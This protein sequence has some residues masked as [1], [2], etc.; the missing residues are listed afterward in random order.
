LA[1]GGMTVE[2]ML[3]RMDSREVAEWQAF[4]NLE[5][6]GAKRKDLRAAIIA[7]T[8]YNMLRRKGRPK[9]V[10]DF[11]PDFTKGKTSQ[12][13]LN[14]KIMDVFKKVNPKES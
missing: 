5:P 13:A 3:A 7:S 9:S 8:N 12:D 2:E 14:K 11:I 1:L 10:T 6:F 4:Y